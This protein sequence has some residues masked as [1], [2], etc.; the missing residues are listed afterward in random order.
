MTENDEGE[1][2]KYGMDLKIIIVGD[3]STGKTSILNRF[4]NGTFEQNSR[5]TIAPEFSYKI[6]KSIAFLILYPFK[7]LVLKQPKQF[8][9]SENFFKDSMSSL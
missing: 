5:A 7:A 9:S 8:L 4:I 2:R 6:I 1:Q 3:L